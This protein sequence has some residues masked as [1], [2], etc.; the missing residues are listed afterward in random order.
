MIHPVHFLGKSP[1]EFRSHSFCHHCLTSALRGNVEASCLQSS[2][3]AVAEQP[4]GLPHSQPQSPH[5]EPC[6]QRRTELTPFHVSHCLVVGESQGV[7]SNH[8]GCW[9]HLETASFPSSILPASQVLGG[10]GFFVLL[11]WPASFLAVTL[12]WGPGGALGPPQT[13]LPW[14]LLPACWLILIISLSL[15]SLG[16][17][18]S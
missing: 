6:G 1:G 4:L 13:V 18:Y 12:T 9:T 10:P 2:L 11:S 15:C 5:P 7:H 17:L 14:L 16:C 8:R 3:S